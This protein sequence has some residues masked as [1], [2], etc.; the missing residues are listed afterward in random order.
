MYVNP[1]ERKR[2]RKTSITIEIRQLRNSSITVEVEMLDPND[3]FRAKVVELSEENFRQSMENAVIF[4][5]DES[6]VGRIRR[7]PNSA[8]TKG[9]ETK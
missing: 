7:R 4:G 8:N 9:R 1:R 5:A 3:K 2:V 6:I